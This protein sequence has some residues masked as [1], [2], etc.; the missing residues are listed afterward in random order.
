MRV[1]DPLPRV[2]QR[3]RHLPQ[4]VP[5]ARRQPEGREPRGEGHHPGQQGH[6]RARWARALFPPTAP[7][8]AHA[9]GEPD[10][11]WRVRPDRAS[12]ARAPGP[13]S[14][15]S[16]GGRRRR[17]MGGEELAAARMR[18]RMGDTSAS[19]FYFENVLRAPAKRGF[20]GPVCV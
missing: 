6:L 1:Q 15:I 5:A 17:Q 11:P 9:G 20:A 18:A 19:F 8:P 12:A 3:R 13:G 2:R 16:S 10:A 4:R 7:A 14:R